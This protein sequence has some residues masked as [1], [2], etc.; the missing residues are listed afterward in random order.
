MRI[1]E[2]EQMRNPFAVLLLT[3]MAAC[4]G[5]GASDPATPIVNLTGTWELRT[6]DGSPLPFTFP[7]SDSGT[8]TYLQSVFSIAPTGRY[9]ELLTKVLAKPDGTLGA[10]FTR[11]GTWVV[12]G[13]T[14]TFNDE[15]SKETFQGHMVGSLLSVSRQGYTQLYQGTG[16]VLAD[17]TRSR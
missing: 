7:P 1:C 14:V 8:T 6:I 2:I 12:T 16:P 3:L 9:S 5:S 13:S 17:V 11:V 10:N 15:T 4:G